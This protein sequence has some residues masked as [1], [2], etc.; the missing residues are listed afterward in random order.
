MDIQ[1]QDY[2]DESFEEE[3]GPADRIIYE[4]ISHIKRIPDFIAASQVNTAFYGVFWIPLQRHGN[5]WKLR[6][7]RQNILRHT[8]EIIVKA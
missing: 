4:I 2:G 5:T 6:M 8:C 1:T 7:L 3:A